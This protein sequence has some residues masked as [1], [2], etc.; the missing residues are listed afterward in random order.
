MST[1][2]SEN[3]TLMPAR[4]ACGAKTRSGGTCKQS[5]MPNGRCRMHGG[6]T[7]SGMAAPSYKHGRYSKYLPS[8]VADKYRE[9]LN[10]PDLTHLREELALIDVMLGEK[11]E[12]LHAGESTDFWARML[13]EIKTY[14]VALQKQNSDGYAGREPDEILD[15]IEELASRGAVVL[16]I[17]S[18][19]QPMLEQRRKTAESENKRIKELNQ[20]F[21]AEQAVAFVRQLGDSVKRHVTDPKQLAAISED[22]TR[23]LN[24]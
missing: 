12:K 14:R 17:F 7:P 5:P 2:P 1:P 24:R 6:P 23:A 3:Q 8:N 10:D 19:I 15:R 21:T 4:K 22:F 16:D 20:T 11:L 18:Q 9:A 13:G